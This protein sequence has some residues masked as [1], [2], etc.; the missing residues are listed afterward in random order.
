M[1]RKKNGADIVSGSVVPFN[2]VNINTEVS[3]SSTPHQLTTPESIETFKVP[4]RLQHRAMIEACAMPKC[5]LV[6]LG[7]AIQRHL[8]TL[9]TV[10]GSPEIILLPKDNDSGPVEPYVVFE[11][12]TNRQLTAIS[13]SGVI[14]NMG[15]EST[16][17]TFLY[18]TY[19]LQHQQQHE[20]RRV[21][22]KAMAFITTADD[23]KVSMA[24]WGKVAHVKLGYNAQKSM[25]TATVIFEDPAA[26][27]AMI[28]AKITCLAVGRSGDVACVAQMGA[29]VVSID[30]S[31]TKKLTQLPPYFKPTDVVK[32]FESIPTLNGAFPCQGITMPMD[33]RTKRRQPH[34][35]IYFETV[36][37][38]QRA[39]HLV[40]VLD[41]Y[42]TAWADVRTNLYRVCSSPAHK[43]VI[44]Q[45]DKLEHIHKVSTLNMH[46]NTRPATAI[47]S[48]AQVST[49]SPQSPK[50]YTSSSTNQSV[51]YSASLKGKEKTVVP[52]LPQS[53]S[54]K[55]PFLDTPHTTA[56][57]LKRERLPR[58]QGLL[59]SRRIGW[60]SAENCSAVLQILNTS[61][62]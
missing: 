27:A 29:V 31:L 14:I 57:R 16:P 56:A 21:S 25:R 11:V 58:A 50:A 2:D 10:V 35:F 17:T 53:S 4:K 62:K 51:V 1:V 41:K 24:A 49:A 36:E 42:K 46:P 7:D 26:V 60:Q 32:I 23:V 28:T 34:A 20:S 43:Q 30:F 22:L 47:T 39:R 19:T 8:R 12:L 40:F 52:C 61:T 15:L 45:H 9:A 59:G 3:S 5:S 33:V 44:P 54:C 48:T 55:M 6:K 13:R 38:W 18:R 37:Q